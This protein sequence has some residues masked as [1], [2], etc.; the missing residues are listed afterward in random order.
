MFESNVKAEPM[1]ILK[2]VIMEMQDKFKDRR[3]SKLQ[4]HYW[5]WHHKILLSSIFLMMIN[6]NKNRMTLNLVH[7]HHKINMNNPKINKISSIIFHNLITLLNKSILYM[8][9]NY[10]L[11]SPTTCQTILKNISQKCSHK[12]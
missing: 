5:E 2:I 12:M 7:S 6:S 9:A 3:K 10:T 11:S 1:L 8:K 4:T